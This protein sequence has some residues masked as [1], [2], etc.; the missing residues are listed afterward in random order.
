VAPDQ[1]GRLSNPVQRRLS[2]ATVDDLVR[3]YTAGSSIDSLALQFGVHRTTIMDH[4]ERR[5]VERRTVVR[6]MTNRT[7]REAVTHY[8]AGESLK[9]VAAR[10]GVDAKSL[11]REFTRGGVPIRRRRG[12]PPST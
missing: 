4:L 1:E 9:V 2:E 8:E 10:F 12:W 11:A 5:G 3:G 6:K 7:V